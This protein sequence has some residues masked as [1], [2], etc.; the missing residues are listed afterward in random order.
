MLRPVL[1]ALATALALAAAAPAAAPAPVTSLRAWATSATQLAFVARVGGRDGLWVA[2]VGS[3][4][5]P[6]RLGPAAC[7]REEEVDAL[8]PGPAG[9]WLCLER[10]VGTTSSFFS[11]DLLRA[12][13]SV[14]HVSSA[15]TPAGDA[16]PFVA[17]DGSTLVYL[18]VTGVG[19]T[20]LM[21]LTA[22][23]AARHVADLPVTRPLALAVAAGHVAVLQADGVLLTTTA[24]GPPTSV[25]IRGASIALTPT[26]LVV[27]T[28][29]RRLAVFTLGG[30]LV[31]FSALGAA[32]WT[33]GLAASGSH[34]V[35][36]GA[37]KA[38]REV[39]LTTGADRVLLRAGRGFFFDGVALTP[40]GA[41]APLTTQQ[42]TSFVVGWRLAKV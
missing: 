13:G 40:A 14:R 7:G 5:T 25:P 30:K 12:D 3:A 20:E 17:G 28:R 33:A 38:V 2:P 15:G 18:H 36:L 37:N 11:V 1:A 27:R 24:G 6:R 41:V 22:A 26:R 31:R 32:G 10:T 19:Q 35:Y 21:Q 4:A 8:A 39:D 34:A 23:G 29:D 42:G 16:I 9:S